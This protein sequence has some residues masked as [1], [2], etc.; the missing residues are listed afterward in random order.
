MLP[1]HLFES[2]YPRVAVAL[3][4][5]NRNAQMGSRRVYKGDLDLKTGAQG[6]QEV[7][8]VAVDGSQKRTST[9]PD[10]EILS[11]KVKLFGS[12]K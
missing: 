6:A 2:H 10:S 12:L 7:D 11:L 8:T 5:L 1:T 9:E 4:S 3:E